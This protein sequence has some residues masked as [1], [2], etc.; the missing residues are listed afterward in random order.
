VAA[1]DLCSRR[2]SASARGRGGLLGL[3][4]IN[5]D[6]HSAKRYVRS[7]PEQPLAPEHRDESGAY[8]VPTGNRPGDKGGDVK[9][10]GAEARTSEHDRAFIRPAKMSWCYVFY[11]TD[12]R[13]PRRMLRTA[14]PCSPPLHDRPKPT[15]ISPIPYLINFVCFSVYCGEKLLD[16]I[17]FFCARSR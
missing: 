1:A 13:R 11:R 16:S 6:E 15:R 3:C 8:F 5:S 14:S 9:R 2:V 17:I 4:T 12:H 7:E 10:A